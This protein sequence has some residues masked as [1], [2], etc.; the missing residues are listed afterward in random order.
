M[1]ILSCSIRM[2][3]FKRNR[4]DGI[5]DRFDLDSDGDDCYDVIEAG[6]KDKVLLDD[7]DG[8]L[9]DSPITVDSLG[10]VTSGLLGDGYTD[11]LD[12]DS[13]G[14]KDYKQYGQSI[15][16]AIINQ[17]SLE[18]LSSGSGSFVITA[19]VP[20]GDKITYQWQ[21][22]RD[23]GVSWF[24]VPEEAPYSGTTTNTL[25]LTQPS[26]ELSGYKYRIILT[27][28]SYVCAEI[29]VDLEVSL[30]VYPDNDKDGVR[31]SEDDDDD[32][33]GILDTWEGDGDADQDGIKNKFDLDSDGDGCDDVIEAGYLDANADGRLGP[34][35]I[36]YLLILLTSEGINTING[37]GRVNGHGGYDGEPNDLDNNFVYD[38]LEEGAPVRIILSRLSYC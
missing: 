3:I 5:R 36:Y 18:L 33:D 29:P 8:Q 9:G 20:G 4:F 28:P 6:F 7:E 10:R 30:T 1:E 26:S 34:E 37:N 14:T 38:F 25:T 32:N 13:D 21:E 22:S 23:D 12:R 2:D 16:D 17:S 11:P 24:N 15:A 35:D 19:S 31:D 27:I